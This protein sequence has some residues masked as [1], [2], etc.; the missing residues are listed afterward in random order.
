MNAQTG[1]D[2]PR[3]LASLKFWKSALILAP[4]AILVSCSGGPERI[5][6]PYIDADDAAEQ[7]MEMYDKDGDGFLADAELEAAPG[8]KA[9]LATLDT[10]EDGKVS[11]QE[12]AERIR[13]WQ[14]TKGGITSIRCYVTMDSKPLVGATVTFEPEAFLGEAIQTAI[15]ITNF[16][17]SAGLSIPKENRPIADMPPGIQLG[18]FR[19]RISKLV[20]GEETVPAKYNT[21]TILG[22][23]VSTD[24]PAVLGR[25]VA[26]KLKSR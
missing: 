16:S 3:S 10:D 12:I 5:R 21:E 19:V 26:F 15:G 14:A 9:A 17:G 18:L 4:L 13:F 1:N 20:D 6:P 22:Q 24:D 7:A 11:E 23:Q 2:R 25:K 8:L